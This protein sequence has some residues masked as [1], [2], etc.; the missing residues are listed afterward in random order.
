MEKLILKPQ[1]DNC[2]YSTF[3][4]E[5]GMNVFLIE[6]NDTDL[7]CATM[8]VKIGYD[9][10][11]VPGIAHF[12]E[13]ML[14]NGTVSYPDEKAYSD[15][16][17][18]NGGY[19][20][21]YTDH[22]HT[23]YYHTV[24]PDE[25]I[26]SLDMFGSFFVEPLLKPDSVDREKNAVN[27]EHIKNIT[28]D[29]W[30]LHEILK[31]AMVKT[32]PM[33]NFGTGSNETLGIPD[34][35]QK[36]RDFF[37]N[38]YSSDLMTL[39]VVTKDNLQEVTNEV[40][41]I[42]SKVKLNITS[43]NRVI[44][45]KQIYDAPQLIKAVPVKDV[46]KITIS[47]DL[48]SYKTTPLR[49][50]HNFLSHII[51][52][53][54]KNTIHY[55]LTQLGYITALMAG[56]AVNSLD[57]ATF[58]VTVILTP[59]GT[60]HKEDI[61]YTIIK[62]IEMIKNKINEPHL[63]RLYNE[64]MVLDAFD[65][66]Y[67]TKDSPEERTRK[68]AELVNKYD[69]D[70]HDILMIPYANENFDPHVKK[71]LLD[72]LNLMTIENSVVMLI[73][74]LYENDA[75]QIL[76]YY[77]AKYSIL[78]TYPDLNFV[79]ID[80]SLLDLPLEN[81]FI[82]TDSEII[83]D[84]DE[85]TQILKH[86]IVKLYCNRT[87]EFK[88]PEVRVNVKIDLP[89][90]GYD[91]ESYTNTLLYFN[92]LMAE[93]NCDI[94]MCRTA[95]YEVDI[96]FTSGKLYITVAGN[97]GGVEKVC[98]FL[99]SSILNKNL[100]SEKIYETV[101]YSCD[102]TNANC[103]FSN[104]YTR[105]DTFFKKHVCP[106]YYDNS[107][108]LSVIRNNA[109]CNINITKDTLEKVLYKSNC[110]MLVIG[111]CTHDLAISLANIFSKFV[112]NN[113]YKPDMLLC[114]LINEPDED[115]NK[116]FRNVENDLETNSALGYYVYITKLKYGSSLNWNKYICF[117][118]VLDRII[119]TDYFDVLRTKEEFGYV[120][121][122]G[123]ESFGDKRYLARFYTFTVQ[124]PHKTPLEI[125]D[126]TNKF[127]LEFKERLESMTDDEIKEIADAIIS[128]LDSPFNNLEEMAGFI[129]NS[130][131]LTEY[132]SFNLK[133]ILIKTYENITKND[134]VEFFNDKFITNKKFVVIGLKSTISDTTVSK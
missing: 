51:G 107:D 53:E 92:A 11:T 5:N 73:S 18:K 21:A 40:K 124:S 100:I 96:S 46:D 95:R 120:C 54:G 80:I 109:Q 122:G 88:I 131:V 34:I 29:S 23:C 10:D 70:L 30:R 59:L 43:Q 38:H 104:P 116:L 85:K 132:V 98:D 42:F 126:R 65:F 113:N 67:S 117:L 37:E 20:N 130:E 75:D 108:I 36:V 32:N 24:Q 15:F 41:R 81:K 103:I 25:L 111:N 97:Y 66:K 93:I 125:F 48:P 12:L 128:T 47:W 49:N 55:F 22:D 123:V 72:M 86:D 28:S 13:H 57:R 35:H 33:G 19:T 114:D 17:S 58:E 94:Y 76:E 82:T 1:N 7:S 3:K 62:Y 106:S 60:Q 50:P 77:G 39:F 99:V 110:T 90:S 44:F 16:I 101:L 31:K 87:N 102:M 9:H 2:T 115:D 4:L 129:F 26:K 56:T 91:K 45:G 27:S 8:M 14:F 112:P 63:E 79:N 68:F 6:D 83:T 121:N 78:H 64:L 69:F 71:N 74:K 84:S 105:L 119:S 89:F 52:H 61:L 118:N 127:L 134:V 133:E